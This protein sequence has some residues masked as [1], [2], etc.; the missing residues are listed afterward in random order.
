MKVL[1]TPSSGCVSP[2]SVP[3]GIPSLL[4][5]L[6]PLSVKALRSSLGLTLGHVLPR[7][8]LALPGAGRAG[9]SAPQRWRRLG[10]RTHRAARCVVAGRA[11][12]LPTLAHGEDARSVVAR[13]VQQAVEPALEGRRDALPLAQRKDAGGV[14]AHAMQEVID[15]AGA[16]LLPAALG[17]TLPGSGQGAEQE[18]EQEAGSSLELPE[19][20]AALVQGSLQCWRGGAAQPQGCPPVLPCVPVSRLLSALVA[21]VLPAC[22]RCC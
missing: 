10:V 22:P 14:V 19:Q 11:R 8:S 21:A 18:Q 6:P 3:P 9:I 13:A 7:V 12:V 4:P 5:L 15:A 20:Q 1:F 17:Q 16:G 2:G